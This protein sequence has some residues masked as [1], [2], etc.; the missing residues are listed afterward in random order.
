ML[1]LSPAC[2]RQSDVTVCLALRFSRKQTQDGVLLCPRA[3]A[4]EPNR[5]VGPAGPAAD[6]DP[7]VKT[8]RIGLFVWAAGRAEP[9]GA[10]ESCWR[11]PVPGFLCLIG[12]VC[13][14][15]SRHKLPSPSSKQHSRNS[16]ADRSASPVCSA[17]VRWSLL[18]LHSVEYQTRVAAA[19]LYSVEAGRAGLQPACPTP[20]SSSH[21]PL[22]QQQSHDKC[23]G[24]GAAILLSEQAVRPG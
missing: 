15:G 18:S 14:P 11:E 8:G 12:P 24:E 3:L 5:S 1:V 22:G 10:G 20:T 9:A 19:L 21:L 17:S 6:L 4:C 13:W 7:A 23:T 16:A 2:S